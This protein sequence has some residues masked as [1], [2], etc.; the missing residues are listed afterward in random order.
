MNRTETAAKTMKDLYGEA[1]PGL[2]VSDPEFAAIKARLI[3]G[4]VYAEETLPAKLRELVILAV[5]AAN[6]TMNEVQRHTA[7]A[8]A[9]GGK[10]EEI[11]EAVYHCAPYIGLGKAENAVNA[12]NE[13]FAE[14]GV[15][16][17]L[18][19]G[20]TVTEESRLADGIAA[21]K[22]IFGAHI[23]A[24]RAAAPENQKNIQ[25]YLSA[26]CFGDFYTRKFLTIPERELLT[27]AILAAQGGCEPQV[28]AH[29]GGNAAVGNGKETLLAALTVCL[30]YIG[31]PR[32]LNALACI[33]EVL[34]ENC[35]PAVSR[36]TERRP[37]ELRRRAALC[38]LQR[39][40]AA[41]GAVFRKF[42]ARTRE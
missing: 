41:A 11:K 35:H 13:V 10:P 26:Y 5:A 4:E 16:L 42:P 28:K 32:I 6:Q 34:P 40:C 29:V 20:Q 27:F 37:P 2:S 12:V 39:V 21:Q 30:P 31:F 36:K 25:D 18:E 14:K 7:A 24:M 17:P 9:A 3:Y 8:L 38:I 33:N 15:A 22:S 23:D 19:S 1:N